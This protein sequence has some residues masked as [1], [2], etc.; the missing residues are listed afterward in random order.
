[1][2]NA[3]FY[4]KE[5]ILEAFDKTEMITAR[6]VVLS[7]IVSVSKNYKSSIRQLL[8]QHPYKFQ[9]HVKLI[10]FFQQ[11][12]TITTLLYL[13]TCKQFVIRYTQPNQAQ[14]QVCNWQKLQLVYIFLNKTLQIKLFV[15]H[16]SDGNKIIVYKIKFYHY[17]LKF[18][19]YI[20]I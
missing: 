19:V 6:F 1:M 7:Y 14:K 20:N 17:R 3:M 5:N 15:R 10:Y 16:K 18:Y 9:G 12:T 11:M 2:G 13:S 8:Y 4:K